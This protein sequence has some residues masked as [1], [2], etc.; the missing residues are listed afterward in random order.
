LIPAAADGDLSDMENIAADAG[1]SVLT[2]YLY[3]SEKK[4]FR[5]VFLGMS[6]DWQQF[7]ESLQAEVIVDWLLEL[8]VF[9]LSEQLFLGTEFY[10]PNTC[11]RTS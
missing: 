9:W 10:F 7:N 1:T 6:G 5:S 4:I 3:D 2:C 8:P 11:W